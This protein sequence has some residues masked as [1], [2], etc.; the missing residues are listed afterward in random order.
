M[1][2]NSVPPVTKLFLS[3]LVVCSLISFILRYATYL[4]IVTSETHDQDH[5]HLINNQDGIKPHSIEGA[6]PSDLPDPHELYVPF[7]ALVPGQTNVL[8]MPW[9]LFTSTFIEGGLI[10]F[11]ISFF[12]I[13]YTG[14][15][16]EVLW[17]SREF[18]TYLSCNVLISNFITFVYYK[19]KLSIDESFPISPITGSSSIIIALLVAIKQRI[20]NHYLLFLNG[21]I[22]L[23]VSLVPFLIITTNTILSII[24]SDPFYKV[25]TILSWL[26]LIIS[27]TYLRFYKEGGSGRQLSLLPITETGSSF[28]LIKGDRT[29]QFALFT[30]FPKPIS[31]IVKF[32]SNKLFDIFVV[33][34]L[35]NR[36]DFIE[37]ELEDNQDEDNNN[38]TQQ[39]LISQMSQ[40]RLFTSSSL[41]GVSGGV[42]TVSL[43]KSGFIRTLQ[44]KISSI[45]GI[46]SIKDENLS[47]S[48]RRKQALAQLDSKLPGV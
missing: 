39:D 33:L 29:N 44:I 19:F 2:R 5:A 46:N 3:L 16:I 41:A 11:T 36:Q 40:S 26:S 4:H 1:A 35:I 23:P 24:S 6:T 21:F 27:W 48:S 9:V 7:I 18:F 31:Y 12:L 17:G 38:T 14:R 15:Y 34:K 47:L 8:T 30:F 25:I 37:T 42:S 10:A 13:L 28:T 32:I 45:F 22:R 43:P 20:P